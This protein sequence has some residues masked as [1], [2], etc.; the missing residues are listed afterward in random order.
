MPLF[1]L[2]LLAQVTLTAEP[3]RLQLGVDEHARVQVRAEPGARLRLRASAGRVGAASEI[4]PGLF[5]A[6]FR[7][8]DDTIPRVAI[9]S[10][11][12]EKDGAL[13][14]GWLVLP[15]WGA[16]DAVIRGKPLSWLTVNIGPNQ[17]GPVRADATGAASVHAVIP[18]GVEE[19]RAG[20]RLV[21]LHVPPTPTLLVVLD[22]EQAQ[23]G[24]EHQVGVTLY[25]TAR[26]GDPLPAARFLLQ[27][28][29]GTVS[30]PISGAPGESR[31]TWTLPPEATG[32][33]R[34]SASLAD[35][36]SLRSVAELA[37]EPP[38]AVR[39][40]AAPPSPAQI[41]AEA[42]R[43]ERRLGAAISPKIG[44]V[45]NGRDFTSPLLGVEGA[46]RTDRF[47]PRLEVLGELSWAFSATS[48]LA[49][50]SPSTSVAV[51]S[52]VDYITA[53][54]AAGAIF[55]LDDR[56][57]AFAHAGPTLARVSS[58]LKLAGRPAAFGATFVPGVEISLGV[59]RRMWRSVPFAELRWSFSSD[60]S[61]DQVL[62][63][64]L[65]WFGIHAGVRLE[66]L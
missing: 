43:P 50:V 30:E 5:V 7:P 18:P 21:G 45:S 25:A 64:S 13:H 65:K 36:P 58:T 15:L 24:R 59:E 27:P 19:A 61:L 17:F 53:V 41:A 34:L 20:T 37:L 14:W 60:P 38:P 35:S 9:L 40:E 11:Q 32:T 42:S 33:V 66:L 8:P 12:A 26:N 63:G 39:A 2:A 46:L 51:R 31:A 4:E 10:A 3:A 56:T 16:A 62:T 57:S 48:S 52:R 23:G 47:G 22:R 1:L 54:A 6:E 49:A 29:E 44:V 28:S 55:A